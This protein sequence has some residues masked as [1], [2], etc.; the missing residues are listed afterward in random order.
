MRS[1]MKTHLNQTLK[2][3]SDELTG[4]YAASVHDYDAVHHH[5]LAMADALSAGIE[6]QFPQR[7]R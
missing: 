1:M 3:A 7:F 4:K 2:E 6:R 5:I